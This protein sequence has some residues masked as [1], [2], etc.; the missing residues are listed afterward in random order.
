MGQPDLT[1][2]E[3]QFSCQSLHSSLCN[4]ILFP[5]LL[6]YESPD[7]PKY[8]GTTVMVIFNLVSN[9]EAL[10]DFRKN[11]LLQVHN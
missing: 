7:T 4:D 10:K 8:R 3:A 6:T 11:V 9:L 5:F 1:G 2:K